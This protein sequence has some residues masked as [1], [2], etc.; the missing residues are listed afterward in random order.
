MNRQ[1]RI[2][3][4]FTEFKN[5]LQSLSD[6]ELIELHQKTMKEADRLCF[7][8]GMEYNIRDVDLIFNLEE[9]LGYPERDIRI[10]I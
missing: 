1:I 4:N 8:V 5:N 7:Q 9:E 3:M 10:D 6:D 2:I